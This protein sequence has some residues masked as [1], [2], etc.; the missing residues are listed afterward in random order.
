MPVS[1]KPKKQAV[2]FV[3]VVRANAKKV[4]AEKNR[5]PKLLF[6]NELLDKGGGE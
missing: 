4:E 1:Q 3:R 5:K 2:S 6:L